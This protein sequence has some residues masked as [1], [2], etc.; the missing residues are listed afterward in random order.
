MELDL[1]ISFRILSIQ[2]CQSVASQLLYEADK[3]SRSLSH[4]RFVWAI[5]HT[6]L[7]DALPTVVTTY[8]P[9]SDLSEEAEA[10]EEQAKA[11]KFHFQPDIYVTRAA[12]ED[13][14]GSH[15]N[16]H[17]GRPDI[18][19][20]IEETVTLAKEQCV[21]RIAVIT[22][23]PQEMVNQVKNTCRKMNGVCSGV[24]IDIHDEIFNF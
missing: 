18:L 23:G 3:G 17:T 9:K 16:I 1:I 14:L 21:R 11:S 8:K 7:L 13:E 2:P 22:C 19:R 15:P 24:A 4:L 20:I 6:Q 10:V 5:R 12:E